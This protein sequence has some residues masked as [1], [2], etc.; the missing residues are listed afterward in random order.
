[1]ATGRPGL[2][3]AYSALF[4]GNTS[5]ITFFGDGVGDGDNDDL[6]VRIDVAPVP[7]PAAGWMLLAGLG[8]L[9]AAAGRRKAA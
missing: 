1:M 7:L 6:G 5:V 2:N 8:A 4:N 3:I 9:G